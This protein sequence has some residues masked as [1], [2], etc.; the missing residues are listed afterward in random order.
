MRNWVVCIVAGALG[1][2][3]VVP[4]AP[5]HSAEGV[6]QVWPQWRGPLATGEAPGADPPVEWS[7]STNIRWKA[8]I[9]GHGLASPLVWGDHVFVTTAVPVG[10]SGVR[11][12]LFRRLT[13]RIV[14]TEG[15][16]QTLQYLILAVSRRDG[17]VVWQQAAREEVPHEGK[18]QTGS[19][20][21][22]SPVTDGEVLCAFFGSPGLYCYDLAGQLL[23]EKDFGDMEIRMGF[24]EGASP[25]L[26]GDTV[27]VNWDHQG[28]SFI[29]AMDKR[30][31]RERWR[32]DRDEI[33]SWAT[34]LIVEHDGRT[35][36]VTS[37]TNRVRSYDLETGA[38]LWDGEGVTLNAIPTPVAADGLVY[39]LSGYRGSQLYAVEL[40]AAEGDISRGDA[41]AWSVDEDTPY[42]P[43]P[44]LHDG[45]LYFTKSNN[46][47]LSAYDA[48]TGALHYGPERLPGIRS[49][50]ASPV[51]AA[52]R[53][54]IPSRDGTTV[55]IEAGPR[56]KVLAANILDDGFD[57]S[58]AVV[59]GELYLRGHQYLYCIAAD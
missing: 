52:G 25:V 51:T 18:H 33:T 6:G 28:Q 16:S 57:A 22:A 48:R 7:E 53:V 43:S 54:Y 23:W 2:L 56:F 49:I 20:A 36:V 37:A 27:I 24:G 12:G 26:K 11:E 8:K 38:L 58:P 42:V 34:P 32:T 55:V 17:Q 19:W 35:Q 14:G 1:A 9:P 3:V 30:T 59:D 40:N 44:L 45:I 39:L 15:A 5:I 46:G 13:R 21:S 29:V 41:I 10:E 50:Y 31:G 4:V 47:I